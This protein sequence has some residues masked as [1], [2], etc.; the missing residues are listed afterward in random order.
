MT[1]NRQA[2]QEF[3]DN[4]HLLDAISDKLIRS[5]IE[6]SLK[7]YIRNAVTSKHYF[8]FFSVITIVA[9]IFS[10]ILIN[11]PLT[12]TYV[13]IISSI[14]AGLTSACAS[15]LNLFNFRKDWELYRNQA[16]EIKRILAENLSDPIGDQKVLKRIEKSIQSTEKNWM[17]MI[18]RQDSNGQ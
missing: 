7:W 10:G 3:N 12:D 17:E 9:P 13:K 2:V 4:R 11:L 16:E 8:Y 15:A 5:R 14:F 1:A 18:S 6:S